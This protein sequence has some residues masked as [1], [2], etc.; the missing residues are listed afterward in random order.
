MAFPNYGNYMNQY[1]QTQQAQIMCILVPSSAQFNNVNL[2]PNQKLMVMSQTEPLFQI[3]TA[4]AMGFVNSK[5]YS[6]S[7]YVAKPEASIEERLSRLEGILYGQSNNA[8]VGKYEQSAV[9]NDTTCT[10]A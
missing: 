10:N 3:M 8:N 6:F 1:Q 9:A 7:D 2:A 4:D 5:T